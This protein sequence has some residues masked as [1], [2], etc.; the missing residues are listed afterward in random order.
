MAHWS[1]VDPRLSN[2]IVTEAATRHLPALPKARSARGKSGQS[3]QTLATPISDPVQWCRTALDF[4]PDPV[5]AEILRSRAQRLLLCCTRQFGKSTITAIKALHHALVHRGSLVLA[6][7]PTE[8]QSGEWMRKTRE[9]LGRLG[10][11]ARGDGQNALSLV[12]PNGSRLVGLPGVGANI[13]G[14]SKA[15]LVL[16]DEAAYAPDELYQALHPMLAVSHG[17]LWLIST[18]GAQLGFFYEAWA[19][20]GALPADAAAWERFSVTAEQCPRIGAEFL[21][22]QRIELGDEVFRREYL[23]EFVAGGEQLISRELIDA[24]L[25]EDMRAF[26]G[27]RPL[28][29][30]G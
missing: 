28:W 30:R 6:A 12:L 17:G 11:K 13:R 2:E 27:G 15:A 5:Q 1:T 25:D 18:P 16:I 19:R 10:L 26:N 8:R 14:F 4:T 22:E 29:G 9:F 7:A 3:A 24:A 20:A 23:C 21:A